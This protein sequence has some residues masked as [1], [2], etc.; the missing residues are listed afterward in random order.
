MN[1]IQ[2][3]RTAAEETIISRFPGFASS[4]SHWG[5]ADIAKQRMAAFEILKA[6]G[7]PSRRVEEWKYTDLRALLRDMPPPADG[8]T[9]KD[10]KD[11]ND[12]RNGIELSSAHRLLFV[13]GVGFSTV[14]TEGFELYTL[15][16]GDKLPASV[17]K[18]L[19]RE[20]NY[21]SNAAVALNTAF[22]NEI[23]VLHVPAGTRLERPLHLLFH[24][25]GKVAHSSF[26]RVLVVVEDGATAT[27]IET[28]DGPDGVAYFD[29]ALVEIEVGDK[30][31]VNHVRH[32]A[33]G[34]AAIVLST[35]GV[36]I[37]T[38]AKFSSFVMT[39]GGA[40]SRHQM[41]F[42][43]T[44]KNS[45]L[46]VQGAMLLRGKQHADNTM[47][48]DHISGGCVGRQLF[49]TVLEDKSHGVFQGLIIVRP[50]SQK[51]DG[52]MMSSALLL[53]DDAEMDNKPELEIFADDVQCGHGATVGA[54]D[55]NLLFYL[56][57]RGIPRK[58][59]ETLLIQSFVGDAIEH[60]ENEQVRDA[61][62]SRA[63]AWLAGR[64]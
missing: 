52:K 44:G 4:Q 29:N 63:N 34:D 32:N 46:S 6:K 36:R 37:G 33:G 9:R 45:E 27:V 11:A 2:P 26:P 19:A 23:T 31:Q 20:R 50:H 28:Q 21:A 1:E 47:I 53:G 54:L 41:F 61:L 10:V 49:K 60:I 14:K 7:L 58:E 40:V 42:D 5:G 17:S 62:M 3:I 16:N 38:D 55:E 56:R 12:Q 51:T 15:S 43:L 30:A 24:H 25:S 13:N 39:T 8:S 59:A 64:G 48:A 35:L 22:M 57:A 18:A